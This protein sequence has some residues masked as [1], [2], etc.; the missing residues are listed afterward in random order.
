MPVGK[1]SS[2]LF[3]YILKIVE[4]TWKH[5]TDMEGSVEGQEEGTALAVYH[6]NGAILKCVC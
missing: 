4:Q 5:C 2:F 3:R 6:S 1:N